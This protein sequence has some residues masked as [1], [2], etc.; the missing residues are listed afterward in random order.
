MPPGLVSAKW[1]VAS[2][3]RSKSFKSTFTPISFDIASKWRIAL[4]EPPIAFAMAI[5]FSNAS[6]VR[7]S[8]GLRLFSNR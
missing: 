3:I 7:I 2:L 1:G 4:V 8:F 5:A 6:N